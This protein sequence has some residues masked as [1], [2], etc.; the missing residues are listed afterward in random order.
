MYGIQRLDILAAFGKLLAARI[1]LAIS[2]T[3]LGKSI[4][5][6]EQP[7]KRSNR[8]KPRKVGIRFNC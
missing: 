5:N 1:K 4:V 7:P 2:N 8:G 6:L 3:I